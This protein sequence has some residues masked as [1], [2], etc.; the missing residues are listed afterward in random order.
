MNIQ[1]A[2]IQK[3]INQKVD[4]IVPVA[5]A[6]TQMA[7]S[8]VKNQPI[9]GLAAMLPNSVVIN[10]GLADRLTAVRDEIDSAKQIAFIQHV[11]PNLKKSH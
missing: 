5:T 9:L 11:L 3:F 7:I 10:H 2:I 1:R 6:T 8:M 4:L